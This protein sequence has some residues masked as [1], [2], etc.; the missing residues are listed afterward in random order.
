MIYGEIAWHE[1]AKYAALM[2]EQ[3]IMQGVKV[4][5]IANVASLYYKLVGLDA[6][7]KAIDE[8]IEVDEIYLADL[9]YRYKSHSN[10]DENAG[11]YQEQ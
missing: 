7:L 4:S 9:E 11:F 3:S 8:M 1:K 2:K 5:L 6:K 10:N